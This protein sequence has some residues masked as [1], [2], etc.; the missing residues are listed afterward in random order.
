VEDSP[1][2]N[3]ALALQTKKGGRFKRYFRQTFTDE[4]TPSTSGHNQRRDVSEIHCFKCDKYGHYARNCPTRKKGRQY[5]S[6]SDIE[7]DPP[8]KDEDNV[9]FNLVQ[10]LLQTDF[11]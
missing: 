7:P 8:K 5:A 4:K 1:D 2:E 6:T 10:F 3:H 9:D 11:Q